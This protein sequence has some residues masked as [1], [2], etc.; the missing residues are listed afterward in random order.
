MLNIKPALYQRLVVSIKKCPNGVRY[1][2]DSDFCMLNIIAGR[3]ATTQQAQNIC[4]TFMQCW[5]N[6]ED[7]GPTLYKCYTSVF[8][9][10]GSPSMTVLS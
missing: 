6:V 5:T 10:L 8:C 4:I 1:F 3:D 2:Q 7:V 9:L